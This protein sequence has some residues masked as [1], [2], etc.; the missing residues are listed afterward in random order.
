MKKS[1]L[2]FFLLLSGVSSQSQVLITLIFGDK[3]NTP[4]LEFGLEG[5]GNWTKV[6]G[7]ESNNFLSNWNLGFYFDIRIKNQWFFYTGV[8]VK[9]RMGLAKLT[10]ADLKFLNA[11]TYPEPGDYAQKINYFQVPALIKYKF[12]SRIFIEGGLQF[13]LRSKTWIE[14]KADIDGKEATVKQFNKD[15]IKHIDMGAMGG[16]G[17]RFSNKMTSWSLGVKY[18]YGFIDIY[19][20]KSGTKNSSIYLKLNIPIGAGEKAKEKNARKAEEKKIKKAAKAEEKAA[21]EAEK[22]GN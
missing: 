18:Y 15:A 4:D 1:L 12:K 5:G 20:D 19:K 9:A 8:L 14:Y 17:Y 6:S 22:A 7:M 21:K 2:I 3:L 11:D 16:A 13:A 10:E